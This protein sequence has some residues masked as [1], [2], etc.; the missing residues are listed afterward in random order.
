MKATIE[1]T[2]NPEDGGVHIEGMVVHNGTNDDNSSALITYDLLVL[3]TKLLGTEHGPQLTTLMKT[4][5][6]TEIESVEVT[7][8]VPGNTCH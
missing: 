8:G 6:E 3:L 1:L 2:D 7:H 5:E 4:L